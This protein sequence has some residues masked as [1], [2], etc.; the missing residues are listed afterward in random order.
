[1][2]YTREEISQ[3]SYKSWME[4]IA[5]ELN[6]AGYQGDGYDPEAGRFRRNFGPY[7]VLDPAHFFMG[8][9]NDHEAMDY[10]KSIGLV[11]NGRCPMCGGD[12][13]GTPGIFTDGFNSKLNFHICSSCR[14]E[15]QRI[16]INPAN[17]TG[18]LV[19]LCLLP[20]YTIKQLLTNL[21]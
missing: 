9:I 19:T 1:M 7:E 18:C 17:N 2:K 11:N 8:A 21:F 13:T 6:N 10:L 20:W 15:G 5:T 14:K 16:S 4:T 3:L 12:I